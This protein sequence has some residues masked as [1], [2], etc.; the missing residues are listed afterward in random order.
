MATPAQQAQFMR[1]PREVRSGGADQAIA[2]VE[3]DV[4]RI[5]VAAAVR[6]LLDQSPI[7]LSWPA[8]WL[9]EAAVRSAYVLR[10]DLMAR[11]WGPDVAREGQQRMD[12]FVDMGFFTKRERPE[13]GAGVQEYALTQ[14]G[15]QYLH[16][17]PYGGDRPVFC[18]PSGRKLI[19]ITRIEF[20][21]F[22]CGSL[23][24]YFTYSAQDWPSW[25]RTEA[26]RTRIADDIGA[27]GSV[28]NGSV[29]LGRLW[30]SQ[31]AL[32]SDV[33]NGSLQSVCYDAQAQRVTGNDLDLHAQAMTSVSG[34]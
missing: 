6:A 29:T 1:T 16:G 21:D 23:R 18:A 33:T 12:E 15:R 26:A 24:V 28:E 8:V 31:A 19:E 4:S 7:C 22:P 27:I 10:T 14:L 32:P 11:D 25:A 3:R 2:P 13:V 9:N 30:Y 17:S 20:G 5:E 34:S